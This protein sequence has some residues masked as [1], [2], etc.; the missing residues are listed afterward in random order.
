MAVDPSANVIALGDFND[1]WFSRPLD[2]LKGDEM[3]NLHETL[4]VHERYTYVFEDNA[5]TLDHVLASRALAGRGAEVDVV[6]VNAEFSESSGRVSD[7]DPIVAR[8][9]LNAGPAA[10]AG[11]DQTAVEGQAVTFDGSYSDP[12]GVGQYAFRWKVSSDNGNVV[13]DGSA[14][15]FTFV[16]R[17]NGTYSLTFTVTDGNGATSTDTAVLTVANAAP[18]AT[19]IVISPDPG[20]VEGHS[21]TVTV[22][23]ADAGAL[24]T[25]TAAIDWGDGTAPQAAGRR[26][27]RQRQGRQEVEQAAEHRSS[28]VLPR[29]RAHRFTNRRSR[30]F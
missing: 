27:Q 7:H 20:A 29:T 17:D 24:D 10:D 2:V 6:H 28:D 12:D 13:A 25:H 15:D 11:P 30:R 22:D 19:G 14:E 18:E 8:F 23:F 9:L 26:A 4:P 16:P 5:Q 3:V 21:T 1:F